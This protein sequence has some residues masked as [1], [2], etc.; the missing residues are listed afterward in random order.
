[1][2]HPGVAMRRA[3]IV[4]EPRERLTRKRAPGSTAGVLALPAEADESSNVLAIT[5]RARGDEFRRVIVAGGLDADAR[6]RYDAG[7]HVHRTVRG[8]G[9]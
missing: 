3:A 8:R 1:M 9:L 7:V 5:R 2:T 6:V 4:D